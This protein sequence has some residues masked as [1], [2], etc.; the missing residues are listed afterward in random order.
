MPPERE[1][2]LW[3]KS[4]GTYFRVDPA[5]VLPEPDLLH[6]AAAQGMGIVLVP[7]AASLPGR[8]VEDLGLVPVLPELVYRPR[9]LR[10]KASAAVAELPAFRA[11][12]Q[13]G[14]GF[15]SP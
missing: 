6:Q 10:L 3:P 7:H 9:K 11:F 2:D 15:L 13:A 1:A 4:D 14:L 5:I 8:T 12:F